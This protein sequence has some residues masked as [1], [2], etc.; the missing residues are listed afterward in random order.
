M[1]L[2]ELSPLE[3][4]IV[5]VESGG[6]LD[7]IG[8]LHLSNKAYG[9]MQVRLPCV[10]DVN[11]V[12]K[13]KYEPEDCL[14]NLEISVDIF[15]KYTALWATKKRTGYEPTDEMRARIWNGGPRGWMKQSTIAYWGKVEPLLE[16]YKNA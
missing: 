10:L 9:P 12:Y 3:R 15:R 5:Q 16:K 8:D 11:R 1:T 7:A 6:K 2:Q 14:N 4:A 13:T